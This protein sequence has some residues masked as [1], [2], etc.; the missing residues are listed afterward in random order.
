MLDGGNFE[1]QEAEQAKSDGVSYPQARAA[2][3]VGASIVLI[4]L[5]CLN[6]FPYYLFDL[7]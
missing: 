2:T 7:G 4:C 1:M 5:V 6:V 3:F